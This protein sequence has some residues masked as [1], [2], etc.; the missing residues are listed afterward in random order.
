MVQTRKGAEALDRRVSKADGWPAA[1]EASAAGNQGTAGRNCPTPPPPPPGCTAPWE[2]EPQKLGT[3][4]R[5]QSPVLAAAGQGDDPW[6]RTQSVTTG[7]GKA[8]PRQHG[9]ESPWEC[10]QQ[11]ESRKRKQHKRLPS[12]TRTREGHAHRMG[13]GYARQAGCAWKHH[14]WPRPW[15]RLCRG[16]SRAGLGAPWREGGRIQGKRPEDPEAS[17]PNGLY[18]ASF[19]FWTW[20]LVKIRHHFTKTSSRELNEVKKISLSRG[21]H[22]WYFDGYFYWKEVIL[23][24]IFELIYCSYF[25]S[26]TQIN[27]IFQMSL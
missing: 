5:S 4:R 17:V 22:H 3:V 26:D 7:P 13:E 6:P 10:S 20:R 2:L 11:H 15:A 25:H 1:Q 8:T 27:V 21:S 23:L 16:C 18:N 24:S 19:S 9:H 14:A 12:G